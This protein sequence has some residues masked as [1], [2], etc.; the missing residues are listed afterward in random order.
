[1]L[2]SLHGQVRSSECNENMVDI[3]AGFRTRCGKQYINV[4]DR[5]ETVWDC[6]VAALAQH[7]MVI[8]YH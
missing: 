6:S 2:D 7:A 8:E 5:S 3:N 4:H 1:M